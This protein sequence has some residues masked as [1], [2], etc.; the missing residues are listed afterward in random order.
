VGDSHGNR[1]FPARSYSVVLAQPTGAAFEPSNTSW[2]DEGVNFGS[3]NVGVVPKANIAIAW[4]SPTSQSSAGA[5]GLLRE[6][7]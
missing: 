7:G 5:A 3:R 1:D 4:D 6:M 2:V